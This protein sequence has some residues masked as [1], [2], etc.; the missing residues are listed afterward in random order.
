MNDKID[1]VYLHLPGV[2]IRPRVG[3]ELSKCKK[4]SKRPPE[5]TLRAFTEKTRRRFAEWH[6]HG[7]YTNV[8]VVRPCYLMHAYAVEFQRR[9]MF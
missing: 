9:F 5:D 7:M 1:V 3:L 8:L 4:A 2:V 6:I